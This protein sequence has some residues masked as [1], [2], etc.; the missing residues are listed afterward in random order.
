M[1]K[2][3]YRKKVEKIF[4][5]L[6]K[7]VTVFS[8]L[9]LA[10]LLYHILKEGWQFLDWGFLSSFPSRFAAKTGIKA[11]IWGTIWL[12]GMTAA[13]AIPLGIASAIFLEEY[14]GKGKVASFIELNVSNL[15]GVPSIV[16]GLLGLAVFVRTFGFGR[17]LISG[18]LTMSLLILPVIIVTTRESIRS[19][20]NSIRYAAYALGAN[21]WQVV[22]GQVIPVA[23]PGILTGIILALSR[24][25]GE[26]APLIVV[27]ALSY[28]SFT[29][30]FVTD[31]FTVMPIQIYNWASK[32]QAE[33][34]QVAASGIVVLLITMITMNLIAVVIRQKKSKRIM[35]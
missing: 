34:H 29:P 5:N 24:A 4:T 9:I 30:T 3:T 31:E 2:Y 21:K 22:F 32:P 28:V 23:L 25:I 14:G 15:A 33:F 19:V 35:T 27:G 10:L 12:I 11:G 18:A 20:P 6:T 16:Y 8:I 26:A 13:I 1:N 7:I 17:S